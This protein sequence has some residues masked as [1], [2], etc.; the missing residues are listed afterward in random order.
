M[1]LSVRRNGLKPSWRLEGNMTSHWSTLKK[2]VLVL[3]VLIGLTA[4]PDKRTFGFFHEN[5]VS[6]YTYE[7]S[8]IDGVNVPYDV[9]TIGSVEFF[10]YDQHQISLESL[11][12]GELIWDFVRF[13]P[14]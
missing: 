8:V 9:F 13:I 3:V 7:E 2:Q 12:P 1:I 6:E 10:D 5:V 11:L 4:T 14:E